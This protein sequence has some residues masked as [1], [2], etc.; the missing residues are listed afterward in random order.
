MVRRISRHGEEIIATAAADRRDRPA[1]SPDRAK[2]H[3]HAD[4][5]GTLSGV[6]PEATRSDAGGIA[7]SNGAEMQF[8]GDF[9]RV[10]RS[11]ADI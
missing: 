10:I 9:L 8:A 7:R 3:D 5:S 4:P 6:A 1:A 11:A 2:A